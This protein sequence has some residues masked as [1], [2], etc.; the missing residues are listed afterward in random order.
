M[1]RYAPFA[2]IVSASTLDSFNVLVLILKNIIKIK[3][4]YPLKISYYVYS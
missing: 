4:S 2:P 1:A 3:I